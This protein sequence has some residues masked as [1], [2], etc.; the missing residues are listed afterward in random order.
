MNEIIKTRRKALGIT[1][2]EIGDYVG[3]SKATVQRWETGS[4]SNMRQDRIKKLSE[5]LQLDSDVLL[6]IDEEKN[7]GRNFV[8]IP[9]LSNFTLGVPIS[10]Q[11]NIIGYDEVPKDWVENDNV[12]A[13]KVKGDSMEPR[14]V[15]EDIV[16]VRKQDEVNS[17]DIGIVMI[18]NQEPICKKIVKHNDGLVLI[19]NNAKYEPIFF[20]LSEIEEKNIVV[21][22]KVIELRA[23]L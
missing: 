1:L 2:E 22:G 12:F 4:I 5:I 16:I 17:G 9:I 10:A 6:G 18:A 3:V 23:K 13:I 7:F 11:K 15:S 8:K 19:S 14:I 21:L 20:T